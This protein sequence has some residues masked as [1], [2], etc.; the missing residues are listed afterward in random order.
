[1][2][3][4]SKQPH[5]RPEKLST[6]ECVEEHC[7]RVPRS[8][9]TLLEVL[10]ALA[11]GTLVLMALGMAINLQLYSVDVHRTQV[12]EAQ[13]ARVLLRMIADDL[14][15][16]VIQPP[17]EYPSAS[18]SGG[19]SGG[20]ASGE[21]GNSSSE[22]SGPGE[23]S[24][25]G[26]SETDTS[27]SSS[28]EDEEDLL[29]EELSPG[30]YGTLEELWVDVSRAASVDQF[31][32][33][34]GAEFSTL[35]PDPLN[36]IKTVR[37]LVYQG[38]G[39]QTAQVNLEEDAYGLV[40]SEEAQ[41]SASWAVN[42]AEANA[43]YRRAVLLAPEVGAIEFRYFD[44]TEW[45]EEWDSEVN[46]GLPIAVEITLLIRSKNT[47]E[48]TETA[49]F[50][51]ISA[52]TGEVPEGW[53]LFQDVVHLPLAEVASDS[54]TESSSSSDDSSSSGDSSSSSSDER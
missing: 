39:L 29:L 12:E 32:A 46:E 20:S 43:E 9:F 24:S 19:R 35:P 15:Q 27:D 36:D 44:G 4:L 26:E 41:P 3:L 34:L 50:P 2:G 45:Y 31:D 49:E 53:F 18:A 48:E 14:R 8:A 37:Y 10:L 51:G 30:L 54:M 42:A 23:D 21:G 5:D 28:E 7:V 40:R 33:S 52:L 16:A 11:L 17:V 38:S 6:K 13:L 25:S 47:Q 1:M 22:E